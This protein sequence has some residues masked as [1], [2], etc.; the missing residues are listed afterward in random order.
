MSELSFRRAREEDLDRLIEIHG[1]AFPDD[2]SFQARHLNFTANR[3]GTLD[4]LRV[5]ERDGVIVA[6]AFLFALEIAFGGARVKCAGIASVG[7][8]PEARGGGVASELLGHLHAEA[9]ARGDAASVLYAFRQGFYARHGYAAATSTRR[10]VFSPHSVPRAWRAH[11]VRAAVGED[12]AAIEAAHDRA[13]ARHT[14]WLA[15]SSRAWDALLVD[16]RRRWLVATRAGDVVGYVAWSL[17]QRETWGETTMRVYE[18]VADDDDAR[19]A[20]FAIVG[21]QRDQVHEVAMEVPL[22]D[23]FD[24]ALVDADRMRFGNDDVEHVLGEIVG[25]PMVRVLDTERALA[26]RGYAGDG[27]IGFAVDGREIGLRVERGRG[28]IASRPA[29]LALDSA[30]FSALVLGALRP[31]D[32]ARLGLVTAPEAALADADRV[33]SLPPYFA[34]DPF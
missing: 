8:A 22:D 17:A 4:D 21:A 30:T 32:A 7:V 29:S 28:A 20:L 5:V 31:S 12:R 27:E 6:H 9:I 34:L 19:R 14:G 25:G 15:R 1:S 11:G 18:L 2:R 33:L 23:P 3:L 16:E 10:L 13:A 26:A 24:R